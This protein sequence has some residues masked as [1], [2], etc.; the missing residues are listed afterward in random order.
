M[1]PY[2]SGFQMGN[3]ALIR[4]LYHDPTLE[5]HFYTQFSETT[6]ADRPCRFF[7]WNGEHLLPVLDRNT[8]DPY[9]QVGSDLLMV[10][11]YRGAIY[12]F[13]RAIAEGGDRAD[14]LTFMGWAELWSGDR[15]AAEM[16]W[17][18]MGAA[19]DTAAWRAHMNEALRR[20]T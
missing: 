8:P 11:R 1:L 4:A 17:K 13:R 6:A 20:A 7:F 15:D 2:Y 5:S 19:D 18:A 12:A 10:G 14:N 16:A 9:F 3:G